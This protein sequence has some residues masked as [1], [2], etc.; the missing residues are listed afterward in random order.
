MADN[1]ITKRTR[2]DVEGAVERLSHYTPPTRLE[3]AKPKLK[4]LVKVAAGAAIG[5]IATALGL[6][7]ELAHAIAQGIASLIGG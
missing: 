3:R 4:A 1:E 7:P 6:S 2:L 5:A